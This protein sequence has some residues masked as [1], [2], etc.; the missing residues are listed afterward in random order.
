MELKEWDSGRDGGR[1]GKPIIL[2]GI[3]RHYLYPEE[4]VRI[5]EDNP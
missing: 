5:D 2:D 1:T 3:E 4:Y